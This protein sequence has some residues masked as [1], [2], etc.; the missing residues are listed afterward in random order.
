M[1][2]R[3]KAMHAWKEQT[4]YILMFSCPIASLSALPVDYFSTV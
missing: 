4:I 2:N 1:P 3:K